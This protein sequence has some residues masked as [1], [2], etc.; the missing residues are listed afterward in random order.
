MA[1]RKPVHPASELAAAL[2][3]QAAGLEAAGVDP[4]GELLQVLEQ[5]AAELERLQVLRDVLEGA[6]PVQAGRGRPE[7]RVGRWRVWYEPRPVPAR[8]GVD[9]S[10]VH[11][12]YDGPEDHRF[13]TARTCAEA[14]EA[15]HELEAEREA[16]PLRGCG[17][18][19]R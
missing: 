12:S 10:Y 17:E 5:A 18:V 11:D 8:L 3:G 9:W 13:G 1:N 6:P 4:D 7:V 14:L 15:V 2:R 19:S 16:G